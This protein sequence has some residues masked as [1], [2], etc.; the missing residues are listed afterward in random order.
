MV[1]HFSNK[2]FEMRVKCDAENKNKNI[3]IKIFSHFKNH[4]QLTFVVV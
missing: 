2:L 3:R 1:S 4:A